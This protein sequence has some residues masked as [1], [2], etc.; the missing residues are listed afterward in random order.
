MV[1]PRSF[2]LRPTTEVAQDLLGKLIVRT[3]PTGERLSGV[4]VETEAYLT[5]DPASHAYRGKT[6]RNAVMFGPPGHAYI[7][8]SYGL[9][10]M[11]NIVTQPEGVAEA[12][13]VRA[14]EP[15]HGIE[16]MRRFRARPIPHPNPLLGKE[17]EPADYSLTNGPGKLGQALQLTVKGENGIDVT[18]PHSL[19]RVM[20]QS[21]AP[22]FEIVSGPRIGIS[23]GIAAPWRYFVKANRYVSRR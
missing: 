14:I 16:T 4:I 7:Y 17:R 21:P 2:Y 23:V 19:L 11:L 18:L 5:G 9:H 20:H 12:V 22:P 6:P 1:L 13:L 10:A 3:L 8:I 15:V